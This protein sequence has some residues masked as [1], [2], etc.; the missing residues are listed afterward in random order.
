MST[1]RD[2]LSSKTTLKAD[3]RK[4]A[5]D[6]LEK[7]IKALNE[8]LAAEKAKAA[9]KE[10][11]AREANIRKINKLLAETGLD[12]EDL[13]KRKAGKRKA[14]TKARGKAGKRA[15]VKPKYR[16]VVDGKEHLWSGRGRAPKVFQAHFDAGNSK[17]SCLIESAGKR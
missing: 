17:E 5:I 4:L 6:E 7:L 3:A 8:V 10:E 14:A 13:K 16:L 15:K 1:F 9:K 11:A 2:L 12:P